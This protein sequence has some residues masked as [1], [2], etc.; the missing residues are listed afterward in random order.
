MGPHARC[1]QWV[2]ENIFFETSIVL[3][4]RFGVLRGR[5]FQPFRL[6]GP[7]QLFGNLQLHTRAHL[8]PELLCVLRSVREH[9]E[10]LL[11][12]GTKFPFRTTLSYIGAILTLL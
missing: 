1:W 6:P 7:L 10:R 12:D 9:G 5:S 3:W 8:L 11:N 4:F 2:P